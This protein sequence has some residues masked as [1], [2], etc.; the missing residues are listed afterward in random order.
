ML[1][2]LHTLTNSEAISYGI[3]FFHDP[4]SAGFF[5]PTG[6]AMTTETR[7]FN[8]MLSMTAIVILVL[9]G[10]AV[11]SLVTGL[12]SWKEFAAAVIPMATGF[13]GYWWGKQQ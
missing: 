9:L 6:T 2:N 5:T 3:A 10:A 4:P 11:Y 13:G 7:Q 8:F 1:G 12:I